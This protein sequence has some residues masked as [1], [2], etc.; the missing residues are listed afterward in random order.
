MKIANLPYRAST[1]AVWFAGSAA[2]AS[3]A[4]LARPLVVPFDFSRGAIEMAV[5]VHGQPLRMILDTGVD[6]SVIDLGRAR[7]L[8]LRIDRGDGGEAT[9]F[10]DGQGAQVF[11]G[12]I[13]QL[14]IGGRAFAPFDTVA[15]DMSGLSAGYGRSLDGVI[16]YSFLADK[17]VLIDYPNHTAAFLNRGDQA[18]AL[19]ATCRQRWSVPLKTVDSFPIIPGF[20]FGDSRAPVSLDTGSNGAVGLFKS[21]LALPGVQAKLTESGSVTRT[22]ARGEAKSKSYV[23]KAPVGFGPFT[24][25]ETPTSVY[26]EAGS[27]DTRVANVG[28]KLMADLKL[29]VLFDYRGK[30]LAFYGACR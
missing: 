3:P 1:M 24:T 9:G 5:K 16:G 7:A 14:T 30:R 12:A 17:T 18:R 19:T 20:R 2:A 25:T 28:N 15:S 10:G 11:P 27:A 4:T 21:A 23:F 6:P 8:G 13:D 29:K 26:S 22:G